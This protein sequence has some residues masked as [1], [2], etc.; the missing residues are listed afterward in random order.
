[1][2][3]DNRWNMQM[4]SLV[5]LLRHLFTYDNN[6]SSSHDLHEKRSFQFEMPPTSPGQSP[7]SDIPTM[8]KAKTCDLIQ[9]LSLR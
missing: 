8:N 1:M 4:K 7:S 3:E 6:N 2:T 9:V 5:K